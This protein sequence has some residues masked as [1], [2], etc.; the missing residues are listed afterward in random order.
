MLQ[1]ISTQ[2]NFLSYFLTAVDGLFALVTFI[3]IV[4]I[5]S[6]AK[7]GSHFMQ[8]CHF[9]DDH[10]LSNRDPIGVPLLEISQQARN[11]PQVDL[12]SLKDDVIIGTKQLRDLKQPIRPNPGEGPCPKDLEIDQIFVNL[13]MHIIG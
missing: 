10:L 9:Y 6:R 12:K 11:K 7:N 3:E 5:L 8:D 2:N 4:W 13:V 1:F